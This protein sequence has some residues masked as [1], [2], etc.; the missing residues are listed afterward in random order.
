[1]FSVDN[2]PKR[3]ISV[4]HQGIKVIR[5]V[6][7]GARFTHFEIVFLSSLNIILKYLDKLFSIRAGLF[8]FEPC[9]CLSE[10]AGMKIDILEPDNRFSKKRLFYNITN[11]YETIDLYRIGYLLDA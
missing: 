5:K 10:I 1:M 11:N 6:L 4:M 3:I 7:L 9:T 8:V 2:F